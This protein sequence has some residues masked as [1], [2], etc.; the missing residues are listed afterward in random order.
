MAHSEIKLQGEL[1]DTRLRVGC[2]SGGRN[3]PKG[4]AG[5]R[6]VRIA[7]QGQIRQVEHFR[8]ELQPTTLINVGDLGNTHVDVGSRWPAERIPAKR[9]VCPLRRIVDRIKPL[10]GCQYQISS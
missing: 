3:L 7:E 10:S 8:P 4:S 6:R 9:A 1:D 5:E 2:A